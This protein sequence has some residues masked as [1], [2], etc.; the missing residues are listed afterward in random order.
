MLHII[1]KSVQRTALYNTQHLYKNRG[2]ILHTLFVDENAMW[3]NGLHSKII[4]L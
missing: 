2:Q 3:N 4:S 1:L